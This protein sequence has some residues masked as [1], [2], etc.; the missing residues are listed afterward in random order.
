MAGVP[1]NKHFN[2]STMR[3]LDTG[4]SSEVDSVDEESWY[5]LLRQFDDANIYQTW[6]YGLVRNGRQNI[7]HLLVKE[8]GKV[9]AV[10]QS[11]IVKTPLIGAV[12]RT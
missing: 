12:S 4:Y 8:G 6:A 10:A 11:R 9:V 1:R 7:S 2:E 5:G 3:E